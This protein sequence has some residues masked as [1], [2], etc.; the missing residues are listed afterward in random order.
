[1]KNS[2]EN[3]GKNEGKYRN[4]P[5]SL[6]LGNRRNFPFSLGKKKAIYIEI[7]SLFP[8]FPTA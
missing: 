5:F 8:Y 6:H 4:F 1:M 3:T 7:V 2:R